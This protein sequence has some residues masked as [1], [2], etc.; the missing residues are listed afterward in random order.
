MNFQ[1]IL[2]QIA[3]RNHTTPEEVYQEMQWAIE[4]AFRHRLDCAE[5]SERWRELSGSDCCPTP[6]EFVRRAAWRAGEELLYQSEDRSS[7]PQETVR[8]APLCRS[9]SKSRIDSGPRVHYHG[10]VAKN[11]NLSDRSE[12][13][14][15]TSQ[16]GR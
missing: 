9:A 15:G 8:S 11:P 7:S 1:A 10:S 14:D 2:T 13:D 6:E 3:Q 5:A 12:S 16:I 4:T